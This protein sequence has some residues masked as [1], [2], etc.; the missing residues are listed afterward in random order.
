MFQTPL[1]LT[2]NSKVK[3]LESIDHGCDIDVKKGSQLEIRKDVT[4]L[5]GTFR[6]GC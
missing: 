1:T 6:F 2:N 3:I 4:L 5:G